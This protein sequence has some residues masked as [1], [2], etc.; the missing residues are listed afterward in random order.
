MKLEGKIAIVT[1]CNGEFGAAIVPGFAAEGCDV[2]CVD[3]KQADTDAAAEKYGKK[4]VVRSPSPSTCEN[5]TKSKP[6]SSRL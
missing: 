4:A 6:W 5:A 2:V 1:G 3:F